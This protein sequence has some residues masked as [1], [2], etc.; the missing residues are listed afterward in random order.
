MK[1]KAVKYRN[2]KKTLSKECWDTIVQNTKSFTKQK[3]ATEIPLI[4]GIY[5][6]GFAIHLLWNQGQTWVK[7]QP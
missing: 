3:V 7:A 5:R 1:N 2:I 6:L 4:K